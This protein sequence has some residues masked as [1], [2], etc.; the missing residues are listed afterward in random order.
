M[1]TCVGKSK[2][3]IDYLTERPLDVQSHNVWTWNG[4]C[5]NVN[6]V[7]FIISKSF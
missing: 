6:I 2:I 3:L 5:L 4:E 7:T 1:P